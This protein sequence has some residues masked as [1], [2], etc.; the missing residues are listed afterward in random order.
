VV[1]AFRR[2]LSAGIMFN[3]QVFEHLGLGLSASDG[4]FMTMLQFQGPMTPGQ[5]ARLTGLST[6]TV[7]GVIDRLERAGYVERT[8]H[9]S[10]RRKVI[11]SLNNDRIERELR[12][13]YEPQVKRLDAVVASYRPDQL[14]VIADFLERV[15]GDPYGA[16]DV[17]EL[18]PAPTKATRSEPG[19]RGSPGSP[20]AKDGTLGS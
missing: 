8:R 18:G 15:T 1:L 16:S 7:T 20:G 10:D 14:E 2:Q 5:L 11:V 12:P 19:R 4:Q 17:A 3:Q 13:L 9:D 6:G